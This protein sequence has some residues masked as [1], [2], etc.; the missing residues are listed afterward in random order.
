ML[1]LV[2]VKPKSCFFGQDRPCLSNSIC[3]C[4]MDYLDTRECTAHCSIEI[5]DECAR[6]LASS[7]ANSKKNSRI[8]LEFNLPYRVDRSKK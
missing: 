2:G 4:D 5:F 8:V 1:P 3:P 6:R 7:P